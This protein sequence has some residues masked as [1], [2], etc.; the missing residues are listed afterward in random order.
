MSTCWYCSGVLIWGSDFDFEDYGL[1]GEGIITELTCSSCGAEVTYKQSND[2]IK[3]KNKDLVQDVIEYLNA[4]AGTRF[5][6]T[7][8]R[9]KKFIKSRKREGYKLEDFKTVIDKKVLEWQDTEMERHIRPDTLFGNKFEY[10]LNQKGG[11]RVANT[12]RSVKQDIGP[13]KEQ[14]FKGYKNS[15]ALQ[16]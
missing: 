2:A 1:E 5:K 4:T 10:Y 14:K 11:G 6:H 16:V 8:A 12:V 9:T 13:G 3:D 15:G 7:T